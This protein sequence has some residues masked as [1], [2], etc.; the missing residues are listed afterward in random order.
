MNSFNTKTTLKV[1]NL[2]YYIFNLKALEQINEKINY[3]PFSLKILLENM[4]RHEDG[5]YV[6]KDDILNLM[7]YNQSNKSSAIAF[8]PERVIMQ[9]FTFHRCTCCC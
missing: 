9:D 3:M 8:F 5:I 4:L 1:K 2:N 6:S 7:N